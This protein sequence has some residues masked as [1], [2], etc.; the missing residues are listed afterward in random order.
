[1]KMIPCPQHG[2]KVTMALVNE[3]KIDVSGD[4]LPAFLG[5]H[6]FEAYPIPIPHWQVCIM[7]PN[8]EQQPD[9]AVVYLYDGGWQEV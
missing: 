2:D 5:F 9:V 6:K 7:L 4:N 1:M 3:A 8:G